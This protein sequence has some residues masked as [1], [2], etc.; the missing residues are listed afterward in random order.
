MSSEI[1]QSLKIEALMK[2]ERQDETRFTTKIAGKTSLGPQLFRFCKTFV[3]S[4]TF[5]A[6]F[7]ALLC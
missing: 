5:G 6:L 7:G 4:Y 2:N 1:I 3:P